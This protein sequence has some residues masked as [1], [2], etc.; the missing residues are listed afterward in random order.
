MQEEV[1]R[2]LQKCTQPDG[3][4]K[5]DFKSV[6]FS[7]ALGIPVRDVKELGRSGAEIPDLIRQRLV[8]GCGRLLEHQEDYM[9]LQSEKL[10]EKYVRGNYICCRGDE[11]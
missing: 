3:T 8:K 2:L 9:P 1:R 10:L 5:S 11:Y 4:A 6:E 7:M